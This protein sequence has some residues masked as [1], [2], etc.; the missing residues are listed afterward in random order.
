M[1]QLVNVSAQADG[2]AAVVIAQAALA[3]APS[4]AVRIASAAAAGAPDAAALIARAG[5]RGHG[6]LDE[7]SPAAILTAIAQ[8]VPAVVS[9]AL[10]AVSARRFLDPRGRSR[11]RLAGSG[12][13]C[14]F[15]DIDSRGRRSAPDHEQ[16]RATTA[17]S[18]DKRNAVHRVLELIS[19]DAR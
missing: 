18:A 1:A 13:P 6:R 19:T 5:L 14:A 10:A 17:A 3:G 4:L 16:Y 2:D 8:N 12:S 15:A 9:E 11:D 7:Q